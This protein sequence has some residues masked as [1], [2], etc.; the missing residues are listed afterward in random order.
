MNAEADGPFKCFKEII[1]GKVGLH[2]KSSSALL[3]SAKSVISFV[4]AFLFYHRET[5]PDHFISTG[6]IQN[7]ACLELN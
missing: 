4:T 3:I 6:R 2:D 5:M 7:T 1:I